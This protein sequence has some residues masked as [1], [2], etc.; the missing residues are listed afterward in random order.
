[1]TI[2]ADAVQAAASRIAPYVRRTPLDPAPTLSER[3][4]LR[5]ALKCEHLQRTGSFKLRGAANALLTLD[6]AQR[7]RGIVTASTGN[8][9]IAVAT[10][11]R[12][13][14]VP[15]TVFVPADASATK[16]AAIRRLGATI[17]PT[18]DADEAEARAR[19]D[20]GEEGRPYVSP[21]NDPAVVAGQGTVAVELL[22]QLDEAELD[23]LDAVVVAV[24]GGGLVSGV[25]TYLKARLP[26]I[27]VVGASPANDAAMAASVTAGR[28]V[29]VPAAPTLSDGTAGGIEHD[30]ITFPLCQALVDRWL[31]VEER[32]IASAIRDVLAD[33]HQLIE[34]AAGVAVAALRQLAPA[35]PGARVA[36]VSCG[37]NIAPQVL[38]DVLAAHHRS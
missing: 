21:Y 5:V 27:A 24:G 1:M 2:D 12:R 32:E 7:E 20:G 15:C 23:G 33:Q 22:D 4:R 19:R 14:G 35:M 30:A 9:G 8:H 31:L 13:L 25:A 17:E 29:G 10:M 26:G 36:V 18:R 28:I 3:H 6:P 38:S 16:L 11:A 37:A 34:G